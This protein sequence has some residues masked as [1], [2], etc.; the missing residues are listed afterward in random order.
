MSMKQ[1]EKFMSRLQSNDTIRDEV[2][3]CGKVNSCVVKV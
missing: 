2:Q 3:R 1:L